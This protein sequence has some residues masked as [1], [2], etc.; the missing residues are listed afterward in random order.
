MNTPHCLRLGIAAAAVLS[1]GLAGCSSAPQEKTDSP[2]P[3]TPQATATATETAPESV[4]ELF[5][6]PLDPYRAVTGSLASLDAEKIAA[7]LTREDEL[8]AQCMREQGFEYFYTPATAEEVLRELGRSRQAAPTTWDEYGTVTFAKKYGYGSVHYPD[9]EEQSVPDVEVPQGPDPETEYLESLSESDRQAWD[10]A[11][12][13][14]PES[15]QPSENGE[16]PDPDAWKTEG[17]RGWA[18]HEATGGKMKAIDDPEFAELIDAIFNATA[19]P[20]NDEDLATLEKEWS[21]CMA[22]D[23][24]S[25]A[26]R[27][28]AAFTIEEEADALWPRDA[29][30]KLDA[31]REPSEQE[32]ER[33]FTEREQPV[34]VADATCA[35]GMD[36]K[37]RHSMILVAFEQRFIDEHKKQLDALMLTYGTESTS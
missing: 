17:C 6:M 26:S 5:T 7:D 35:E 23:G 1:I 37:K 18:E 27:Q 11:L 14:D 28:D 8:R 32:L 31:N 2:E 20:D 34:A 10:A 36:Y 30:G 3:S 15:R 25:F 29:D 16:T 12:Y 19:T 4:D 13:G 9:V 24:F 22:A 21:Q 33:F